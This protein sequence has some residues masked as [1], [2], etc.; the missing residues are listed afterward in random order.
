ML[1]MVW[2]F[3]AAAA[4]V[5]MSCWPGWSQ[6]TQPNDWAINNARIGPDSPIEV[7]V[8]GSYDARVV[9]PVPDGPLYPLKTDVTWW[10][11]PAVRGI[12][13]EAKSGKITVAQSVPPG[14]TATLHADVAG[15][16]EKLHTKLYVYS[17][18]ANPIV[19]TWKIQ[20]TQDCG[21][22]PS[23]WGKPTGFWFDA[24]WS[25]YADND[26]VIGRPSGIRGGTKQ[27]GAYEFSASAGSLKMKPQWPAHQRES[28]WNAALKN[29]GATLE[30]KAQ[31]PQDGHEAVCGYTLVRSARKTNP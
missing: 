5:F 24:S 28:V 15:R 29:D 9:Y 13:I 8:G 31:K 10:I 12:F 26:F 19:G 25:F 20:S 6:S 11:E 27:D 30:L 23:S 18:A 17:P 3:C 1:R 21:G 22:Q 4:I 16:K 14:T 2:L 7:P